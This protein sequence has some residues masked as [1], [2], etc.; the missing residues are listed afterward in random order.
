MLMPDNER[1]KKHLTAALVGLGALSGI[2]AAAFLIHA[3][4]PAAMEEVAAHDKVSGAVC[5][6]AKPE[7]EVLAVAEDAIEADCMFVGCGGV[8]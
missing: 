2:S 6:G 5:A 4:Q 8:F 3:Q 1:M 7:G